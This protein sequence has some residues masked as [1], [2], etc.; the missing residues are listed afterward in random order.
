MSS[1]VT[2]SSAKK[3]ASLLPLNADQSSPA[4]LSI[5][6]P[7]SLKR[8]AAATTSLEEQQDVIDPLSAR[9]SKRRKGD[10]GHQPPATPPSKRQKKG[11]GKVAAMS[12][13]GFVRSY[14][15]SN[16]I[17]DRLRT[18]PDPSDENLPSPPAVSS[19]SRRKSG[20]SKKAT[21]GSDS[22]RTIDTFAN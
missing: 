1:R 19:S 22:R 6:Q 5:P 17:S 4:T 9:R 15:P 8:K 11:K 21:P 12:N 14:L 7:A 18:L 3:S 20:K 13:S 10:Q 2:R 16:S